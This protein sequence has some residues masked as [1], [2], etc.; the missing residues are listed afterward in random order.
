MH[1]LQGRF[2]HELLPEHDALDTVN[3]KEPA[4]LLLLDAG[5]D[6]YSVLPDNR[7]GMAFARNQCFP[8]N[9]LGGTPF[10][11]DILFK[12][13]AITAW[14]APTR[15]VFSQKGVSKDNER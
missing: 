12:A 3:A 14:P 11:G 7:G 9:V 10:G 13:G 1:S 2:H 15:P 6:K 8:R 4:L 5:N